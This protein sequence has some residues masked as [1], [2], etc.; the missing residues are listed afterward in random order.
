MNAPDTTCP[1]IAVIGA[2][3]SGLAAAHR[4]IELTAGM[5]VRP[6]V[7]VLE[8][9]ERAGGVILTGSYEQ[10][11]QECGPDSFITQKPWALALCHRLGLSSRII[12]TSQENRRTFVAID[13]KLQPLPDG[14]MML[15]PTRWWPF[16]RS[17]LLSPLG[18]L[19]MALDMVLPGRSGD[20]DESLAEFV[21]RRLGHEALERIA[22]P[23]V[24]GIYT[25]DPDRLSLKATMPRF[26]ELEAR[27]GSLIRGLMAEEK[28]RQ[29][30]KTGRS[31]KAGWGSEGGARYGLFVS[32]DGGL[33]VL[34][35][36]LVA[37]LPEGTIR[38]GAQVSSVCH[39]SGGRR[40]DVITGGQEA[41]AVDAVISALPAHQAAGILYRL[42]QRLSSDLAK[43]QFASSAVLN[44]IYRRED[45]PH[46]L[47]GFG[48]V[49]PALAGRSMLACTFSSL[50]FA[51]RAPAGTVSM[52]VFL[53][54]AMQ[55]RIY[56][57]ADQEIVKVAC[58]DL[59]YF[60]G[61]TAP[62][63]F[64]SLTRWPDSMPQYHLGHLNLV[65]AI[66]S[67]LAR[68]PALALAGNSLHGVG[69]PDCIDSG[70]KAA[71]SIL[72]Q[73]NWRSAG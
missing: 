71:E 14:F 32:L 41:L 55:P 17:P 4:I 34:V 16:I 27:H 36:A 25:A 62:P 12:Q 47:D 52:R 5:A 49:V 13:S 68:L 61:V 29:S 22:Q 42:D 73:L 15:A 64:T 8:A 50:K 30:K 31:M 60:L 58:A 38:L 40:W 54:G 1:R 72:R 63:L 59:G 70:E 11:V 9:S 35:E 2:G 23:M 53:G 10:C 20:A 57:L 56:A 65:A 26:H 48:F 51:G 7:I 24:A 19:R 66:E 44:L 33:K 67:A 69:I 3:I 46:R 43:I 18:K 37:R 39:G 28:E 45:I 6:Q 21:E